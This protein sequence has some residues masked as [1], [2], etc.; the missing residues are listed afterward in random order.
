[1]T[2]S[3]EPRTEPWGTPQD[4]R[5]VSHLTRKQ[6][7][8]RY[9][10]NQQRTEPWTPNQDERQVIKMSWTIVSKACG[11]HSRQVVQVR[12]TSITFSAVAAYLAII[13]YSPGKCVFFDLRAK[14]SWD[15]ALLLLCCFGARRPYVIL[16]TCRK[17]DKNFLAIVSQRLEQLET[18]AYSNGLCRLYNAQGPG[19]KGGLQ[20]NQ[21][22]LCKR[23]HANEHFRTVRFGLSQTFVSNSIT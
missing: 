10:L 21:I 1:M 15:C 2:K 16:R 17:T 4:D 8:D 14:D 18:V 20:W 23:R 22:F 7:K 6:Q 3:S 12:G 11:S 19:G 9:D 5:S 13:I